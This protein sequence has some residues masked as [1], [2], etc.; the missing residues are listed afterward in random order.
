MRVIKRIGLFSLLA[1]VTL[2]SQNASATIYLPI[3]SY[4]DGQWQGSSYYDEGDFDLHI[5]FAVYDSDNMTSGS[6]AV[7]VNSIVTALSMEGQYIYTYQIFNHNPDSDEVA[8]FAVFDF[9]ET[10]L[11]VEDGIGGRNDGYGGI[12]PSDSYFEGSNTRAAWTFQDPNAL[13]AGEHSW[14]L[15]FSSDF[16]PIVGTYEVRAPEGGTPVPPQVP[17]PSVVALLGFGSVMLFRRRRS[18]AR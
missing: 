18:S 9:N 15:A 7:F 12:E 13:T 1:V 3:S 4:A 16:E 6:E 2:L 10:P 14:F 5:D 17:E 8:Y 11:L